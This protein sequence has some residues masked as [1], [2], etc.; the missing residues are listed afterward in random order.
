M[1]MHNSQEVGETVVTLFDELVKLG[2]DELDRCG[3]GIMHDQ[4]I[5]EAWTASKTNE[6]KA[7]LVIGHIDMR[8]HALL[9]GV[10]EGWRDKKESF[11]Y[12]LEGDDK[13][14]YFNIINNQA[15]YKAKRDISTL[16]PS[17]VLTFL[18]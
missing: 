15:N 5:M 10:Y 6:A 7:E 16:P 8:Q 3:I 1:A 17:V 14:N 12:I 2:L 13:I 11:Q 4:Y 18:F 9:L